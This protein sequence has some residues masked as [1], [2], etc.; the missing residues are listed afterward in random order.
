MNNPITFLIKE[1]FSHWLKKRAYRMGAAISFYAIFSIAPLFILLIGIVRT[2]FDRQTTQA[3]IGHTLN[4]AI[5]S[6][7]SAVIQTMIS[8]AYRSHTGIITT[9]LGGAVLIIA[10]VSVFS[11]LNTDLDDLWEVPLKRPIMQSTAQTIMHYLEDKVISLLL[12]LFCGF[13]LLI[14]VAFTVFVSFFH[15][16]GPDILQVGVWGHIVNILISLLGGTVLFST[17]YRILPETKLPWKEVIAGAFV[18]A[19]LFLTG[20]F[21]I[22]W[23][24]DAFGD[25]TTFGAAGSIVGL[26]LWVYYSAQVFFIAAS[27]TFT[28]SKLYGSLSK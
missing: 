12:I 1:T 10:A 23:Y 20:R 19:L 6:N 5:G 11:E 27:G 21:L 22:S 24:I 3:A 7:L 28:Y 4:V 13:L 25:T 17:I 2:I 18:T 15:H 9:L 14:S 8:S 26:L 16:A